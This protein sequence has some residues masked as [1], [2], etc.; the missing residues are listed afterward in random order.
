MAILL[1]LAVIRISSLGK[2]KKNI[3]VKNKTKSSFYVSSYMFFSQFFLTKRYLLRIRS[4]IELLEL[5]DNWTINKK[6]MRLA[7]I[8][9]G[10][11]A[12]LFVMVVMLDQKLYFIIIGVLTIYIVHNQVLKMLIE[13]MDD[14]L[15]IQF[16]RF[17]GDI[18]HHYHEHGMI[19]EAIYDAMEEGEYEIS[20]HANKMYEVLSSEDEETALSGYYDLVPNKF[21]KTFL[22]LCY[23]VQKFGDQ[24]IDGKSMFLSNLNYLKQEINLEILRRRKINYLFKSLSLIAIT[25]IFFLSAIENWAKGNLPE[26]KIYYEGAYGFVVQIALFL[27]V[28]VCYEL[29][30]KM[31]SH[32]DEWLGMNNQLEQ[33]LLKVRWIARTILHFMDKYYGKAQRYGELLKTTG[34]KVSIQSFYLKRILLGGLGVCLGLMVCMNVHYMTKHQLLNGANDQLDQSIETNAQTESELIEFDKNYVLQFE[35]KG[36]TYQDVEDVLQ[37]DPQV[38]KKTLS[39]TALRILNKV[40]AY[41]EQYFKW[42]ELLI[43]LVIGILFYQTPYM[44][45][46]FRKTMVQMSMEDEVMQFHTII[47]ML[48]HIERMSVEDLLEWMCLFADTFKE[49]IEKCLN[50]FEH[51]DLQALEQLKID[52]P[53]IPFAR[54]VENLQAATDLIA[55]SQAF[56]E[57]KIERSY[58]QEKRKQDNEM[59]ISKK[60][61]WGKIIAFIP[62][63]GTLIFYLI[64][65]FV[66]L[67]IIQFME[68]S[69]QLKTFL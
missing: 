59:I 24:V 27:T 1:L 53:F 28:I 11:S 57:L 3:Q 12:L 48:M 56:D 68:Y 4:R 38:S 66:H 10:L 31:Q 67:S 21:F 47:L 44:I 34:V 32:Q 29:I 26:L 61:T 13:K 17:L 69:N 23:T 42:W 40:Q 14:K 52:E 49:S 20:L 6:T 43:C 64:A 41:D 9:I 7:I 18:R 15:L 19:D 16:E 22:A 51:G 50:N 46:L 45:L 33:K 60:G 30:N 58:Y 5:S 37:K 65:P 35:G 63:T 55:I 36:A 39:I 25:P 2:N 62:M 8:A 54:I